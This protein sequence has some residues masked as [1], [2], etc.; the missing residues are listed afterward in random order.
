[1]GSTRPFSASAKL[2]LVGGPTASF[3]GLPTVQ[4]GIAKME[5]EALGDLVMNDVSR[6][7]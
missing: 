2:T 6:Y 3:S 7:T 5:A 4:Y 1:M